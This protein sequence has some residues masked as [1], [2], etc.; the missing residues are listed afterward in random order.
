MWPGVQSVVVG[1][2]HSAEPSLQVTEV[3][4]AQIFMDAPPG[5]GFEMGAVSQSPELRIEQPL[6]G[7]LQDVVANCD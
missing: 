5:I 2:P 1:V 4:G 3:E 7:P 6:H